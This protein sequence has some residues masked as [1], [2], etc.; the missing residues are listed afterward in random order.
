MSK[1]L[2]ALSDGTFTLVET[3]NKNQFLFHRNDGDVL[4]DVGRIPMDF[5]Q[6]YI[7]HKMMSGEITDIVMNDTCFETSID[8]KYIRL[9]VSE[10]GKHKGT[11]LQDCKPVEEREKQ[12]IAGKEHP[13]QNI[14]KRIFKR[15]FGK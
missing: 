14:F 1:D 8:G 10:I 9:T 2:Y 4:G 15:V 12:H 11:E 6:T 5:Y 13:K 7:A 3:Q